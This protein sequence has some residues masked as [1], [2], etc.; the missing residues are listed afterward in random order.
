MLL[1]KYWSAHSQKA[2]TQHE[3]D[4]STQVLQNCRVGAWPQVNQN[5]RVGA[6]TT[7]VLL[8]WFSY[9]NV[10]LSHSSSFSFKFLWHNISKTK[11]VFPEIEFGKCVVICGY[12]AAT[13]LWLLTVP[14]FC[15][16]NSPWSVAL[17]TNSLTWHKGSDNR[18]KHLLLW[19]VLR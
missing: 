9:T 18:N 6:W 1:S 12:A 19:T 10:H 2:L 5:C 7:T 15:A 14:P 11:V 16:A 3:T 17:A 13:D 8:T 4:V